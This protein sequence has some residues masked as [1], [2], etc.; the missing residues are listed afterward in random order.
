M[1]AELITIKAIEGIPG[2]LLFI[3]IVK[4]SEDSLSIRDKKFAALSHAAA[5]MRI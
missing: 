5:S 3:D 4:F 1:R 2:S